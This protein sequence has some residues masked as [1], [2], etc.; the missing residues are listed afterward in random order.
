MPKLYNFFKGLIRKSKE[1][2]V[3]PVYTPI[4]D[5]K[6]LDGKVVMITGGTGGIGLAV[7]KA[8]I[9]C[10]GNVIICGTNLQ[11][12]KSYKE[13]LG[14]DAMSLE[15]DITDCSSLQSA[16]DKGVDLFSDK[17]IDILINAAGVH[18]DWDF[19]EFNENEFDRIFDVNIKG[20]Y[21]ISQIAAKHMIK[22][23]IKGHILNFAS[24]SSPGMDAV[25]DF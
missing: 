12:L 6:I 7:A 21:C 17:R 20:T 22:N 10:G 19:F 4:S 16:F 5:E 3:I 11:K 15:M 8:V 1:K 2:I 9:K 24:S 25:S 23:N 18:G 13:A 14:E